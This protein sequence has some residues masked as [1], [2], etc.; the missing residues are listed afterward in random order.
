MGIVFSSSMEADVYREQRPYI[1]HPEGGEPQRVHDA[2]GSSP[3]VSPN[4]QR[5]AFTRG[6]YYHDWGRRHYRG[7]DAMNVWLYDRQTE[8]GR[9]SFREGVQSSVVRA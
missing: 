7:P 4:G 1:V 6:G 5:V 2:F 9:V 3:K 8:I